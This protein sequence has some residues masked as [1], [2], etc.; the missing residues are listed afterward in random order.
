MR[1]TGIVATIGLLLITV[2][3]A[4]SRN[5]RQTWG[6]IEKNAGDAIV[7][8]PLPQGPLAAAEGQSTYALSNQPD[9]L[10][11]MT[12]NLRV[13]FLLDGWNFWSLR[14]ELVVDTIRSFDPDLLGT[15]EC[16]KTSADYLCDNLPGYE[17]VGVGRNDG[18]SRGEMCGMFFKR[19][20]Y[21][22]VEEGHFWLSKTPEKIGSKGWGAM[23]PRMVSWVTL[24][25]RDGGPAFCWF[26]THFDNASS[27][28]RLE[29]ARLL[30]EA[31]ADIA[32]GMPIIITGDF[33]ANQ[34]TPPYKTLLG[35]ARD[36]SLRLYDAFRLINADRR[37]QGTM[38]NFHGG[39]NGDRID[40][41]L[42]N[43]F[44]QPVM[45]EIDYTQRGPQFPSDH[46]PVK[47]VVRLNTVPAEPV[48]QVN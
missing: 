44:F 9:D 12:F 48:A 35:T 23:A 42:T 18:K 33:N 27:R 16:P 46:F 8:S 2:G 6:R 15:Q 25:P 37:D 41:I 1:V 14:R 24:R 40:W 26:N 4:S 11:V 5:E 3:C 13:P 45:C 34:H 32:P 30:R 21:T 7:S 17:F 10:K 47:A 29:S 31:I 28:A 43:S 20:R 36:G 22:K 38:H 39:K 19:D